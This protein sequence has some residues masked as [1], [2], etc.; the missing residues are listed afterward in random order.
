M[1]FCISG[2]QEKYGVLEEMLKDEGFDISEE[3]S[4]PDLPVYYNGRDLVYLRKG[5]IALEAD[6]RDGYFHPSK[7]VW[8]L[9]ENTPSFPLIRK[10][11]EIL[12]PCEFP[13]PSNTVRVEVPESLKP[14]Q[15]SAEH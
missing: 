13:P 8:I 2:S 10:M 9:D 4:S 6:D 3:L 7:G 15:V 11:V 5:L 12:A 1:K 14:Y